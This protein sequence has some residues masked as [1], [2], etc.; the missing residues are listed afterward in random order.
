MWTI[1]ISGSGTLN[2]PSWVSSEFN[3]FSLGKFH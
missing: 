2:V 3:G 1:N